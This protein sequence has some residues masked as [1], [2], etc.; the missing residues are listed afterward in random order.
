MTAATEALDAELKSAAAGSAEYVGVKMPGALPHSRWNYYHSQGAVHGTGTTE[1]TWVS[2]FQRGVELERVFPQ[3]KTST[4]RRKLLNGS[5]DRW[6]PG[7]AVPA[8][9]GRF[10]VKGAQPRG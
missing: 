9:K 6:V 7:T 2:L 10:A 4:G 1:Q 5:L 8:P 3:S